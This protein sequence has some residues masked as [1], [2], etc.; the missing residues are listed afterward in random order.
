M[1][2]SL[3]CFC[4]VLYG[5]F[6]SLW[7]LCA[8]QWYVTYMLLDVI[9]KTSRYDLCPCDIHVLFVLFSINTSLHVPLWM[10]KYI[11]PEFP[12]FS[13]S[14]LFPFFP[15]SSSFPHVLHACLTFDFSYFISQLFGQ[16]L[17]LWTHPKLFRCISFQWLY[18]HQLVSP[19]SKKYL[20]IK[21]QTRIWKM[22]NNLL[23]PFFAILLQFFMYNRVSKITPPFWLIR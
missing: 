1:D 17:S 15:F 9:C 13:T 4:Y 22:Y 14:F 10:H 8:S 2:V 11:L 6:I 5:F 19:L 7:S 3:I 21:V 16:Q 18:H 23:S 12:S 20:H